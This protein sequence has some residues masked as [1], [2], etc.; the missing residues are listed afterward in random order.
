MH[1]LKIVRAS[2][3]SMKATQTDHH[4][5]IQWFHLDINL[6]VCIQSAVIRKSPE[7]MPLCVFV[8]GDSRYV[9]NESR[10]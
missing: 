3:W 5:E 7:G 4:W 6:G 2:V 10:A 8:I 1:W 9:N